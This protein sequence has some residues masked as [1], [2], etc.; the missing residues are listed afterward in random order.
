[1]TMVMEKSSVSKPEKPYPD[2]PLFPHATKRWAKKIRG[3]LHYFGPWADPDAALDR[4]LNER[5]DLYAGRRPRTSPKGL[6]LRDSVNR[7]LTAKTHLLETG[8]IVERTFRDYE[9]TCKRLADVFGKTRVVEDLASDD[10]EKLREKLAKTLGPVALGNEIQRIRTVFK[11]AYDAGLIEKPVR[12]GPA[13]KRPSKRTIRK[14]RQA[15]GP[16]MFEA[17]ELRAM[18]SASAGQLRAMIFLGINCGFGNHDCG[19]LPIEAVNLETGW[20]A[21]PRPKTGTERRCPLWPETIEAVRQVLDSRKEPKDAQHA[22]LL[23]ITKYGSPWAKDTPDNPVMQETTKLLKSLKIHRPGLSFYAL[24]HTL[25]TIAGESRDQ[26][27]VDYIM[28]HARDDMASVYRERISDDRLIAVTNYVRKWL[29]ASTV[30]AK[31]SHTATARKRPRN[32][33][34]EPR[35]SA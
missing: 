25:E 14:A 8:E 6:T 32:S 9:Q 31:S 5:D 27:A 1:M 28:G 4:F 33:A 7:F 22:G 10:F 13:F 34:T 21:F 18:L 11:Y 29:F 3:K 15:N 23:F 19:S 26:V 24:R 12:F 2:S 16:R 30:A 17:A 20:V 35:Q